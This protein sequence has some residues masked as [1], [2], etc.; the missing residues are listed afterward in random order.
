MYICIFAGYLITITY[1][2]TCSV[3]SF[4][5]SLGG[6]GEGEGEGGGGG[7]GG[8]GASVTVWSLGRCRYK[9][10][11]VANLHLGALYGVGAV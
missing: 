9:V 7:G 6:R 1:Q 3:G 8:G 10:S 5:V 11:L 4:H 2:N